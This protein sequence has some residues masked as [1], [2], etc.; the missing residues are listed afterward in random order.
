[1]LIVIVPLV[2]NNEVSAGLATALAV[3]NT[4]LPVSLVP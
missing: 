1:V 2:V 4:M 3:D